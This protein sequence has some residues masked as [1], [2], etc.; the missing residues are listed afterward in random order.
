MGFAALAVHAAAGSA[1]TQ[2]NNG[3]Y[4]G[5]NDSW[6]SRAVTSGTT[7]SGAT[8]GLGY[9]A[10][11]RLGRLGNAGHIQRLGPVVAGN[12]FGT[13]MTELTGWMAT[14]STSSADG[15]KRK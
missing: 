2:V 6:I 9:L 13:A 12:V 10:S 5:S 8:G 14:G 7:T 3:L 11:D 4:A 1:N 15:E